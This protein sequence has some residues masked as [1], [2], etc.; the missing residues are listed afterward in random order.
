MVTV[1]PTAELVSS[2]PTP[3]QETLLLTATADEVSLVELAMVR[4]TVAT[5]PFEIAVELDPQR[6]HLI[7]PAPEL[8][9]TDLLAALPAAPTAIATLEKSDVE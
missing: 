1:A 4:T 5:V 6:T 3:E 9:V 8:Q 2:L 7:A